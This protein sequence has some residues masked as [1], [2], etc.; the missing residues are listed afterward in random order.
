MTKYRLLWRSV[1]YYWK[2]IFL[3][4]VGI[5]IGTTVITGSMIIGKSVP[6]SLLDNAVARIGKVDYALGSTKLFT[7]KFVENVFE[8]PPGARPPRA[9]PMLCNCSRPQKIFCEH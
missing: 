8:P 7:Q 1:Q 6:Q 5:I 2:T 3:I 9:V 4:I